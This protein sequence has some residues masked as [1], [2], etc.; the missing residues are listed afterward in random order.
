MTQMQASTAIAQHG[1]LAKLR[2]NVKDNGFLSLWRGLGPTLWRDVPF[3]VVYWYGYEFLRGGL[4]KRV[5]AR[6]TLERLSRGENGEIGVWVERVLAV[7][8]KVSFHRV[9]GPTILALGEAFWYEFAH[10]IV[11]FG[12]WSRWL[13]RIHDNAV[14]CCEDAKAGGC[15]RTI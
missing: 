9:G 15:S 8:E 11:R 7:L 12:G 3:S 10:G 1:M 5:S 4:S 6:Q 14:R 2:A 13:C